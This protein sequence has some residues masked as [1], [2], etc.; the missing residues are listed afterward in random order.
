M[1]KQIKL[2]TTMLFVVSM[3]MG[4]LGCKP[5][6]HTHTFAE[7]WTS[8]ETGHWH[9][10]TCGCK[11]VDVEK[12]GHS[13]CDWA[14]TKEATEEAEGS[15]ERSC[16]VCN[17]EETK[18]IAKLEHTHKFS[19]KWTKDETNH[20]HAATCEDTTEVKDKA[21]HSFGD[22]EKTKDPTCTEYGEKVKTCTVCN[23]EELGTIEK[24]PHTFSEEWT[25]NNDWHWHEATCCNLYSYDCSGFDYHHYVDWEET[26]APTCTEDGEKI[27][28][29][30]VCGYEDSEVIESLGHSLGEYVLNNDATFV[31]DGTK[32]STCTICGETV[33]VLDE[34]SRLGV[35]IPAGTFQMGSEKGFNSNKPAHEVTITKSFYMGKYEVTQA[36]YEKYCSYGSSSPS[37]VKG[38]GEKYPAY[39]VSW[40]DA[41]VYC[42][43]RSMAEE[44]TPC[45]SI[46]SSTNPDAWGT[47]PTDCDDAWD[48][49]KCDWNAN[50]YRLPTEAEWEYAARAGDN[51]VDSLIYSG[52]SDVSELGDYAWYYDNS[53]KI[54]HEVGTK[55]PNAFGLYDMSGNVYEWCWNW[56]TEVYDEG[57]EG[58]N[59]PTGAAS[60][61]ERVNR[62][63]NWDY[64]S[65]YCGVS[66]RGYNYPYSR[67]TLRGFRVVRPVK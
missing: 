36:E 17:Y 9:A 6:V 53:N 33:T 1:K 49:V 31:D 22:W 24:L 39:Y 51:T 37:S 23:Y 43:K 10:L 41:L 11:D 45:Y 8:D 34:G 26:K 15:K 47:V 52:T 16:E 67:D 20:W 61:A 66:Y 25:S 3:I 57:T 32:K 65:G 64:D 46:N 59:D 12:Q 29:C 60:G 44:L 7:D 13:F 19:Q 4:T 5:E 55:S 56:V 40:Y 30:E 50:G 14:T 62:G 27:K 35:L 58:G 2:L 21:A 42:N 63:G 54:T 38:Y 48:A 18:T 28:T